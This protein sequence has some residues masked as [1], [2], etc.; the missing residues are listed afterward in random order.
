MMVIRDEIKGPFLF[1]DISGRGIFQTA[2]VLFETSDITT[3]N[4]RFPWLHFS[5]G[6]NGT[7]TQDM[8]KTYIADWID[9]KNWIPKNK[10]LRKYCEDHGL[11]SPKPWG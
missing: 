10:R 9:D 8:N 7:T 6:A 2:I 3:L 1:E 4:K 11:L 5:K